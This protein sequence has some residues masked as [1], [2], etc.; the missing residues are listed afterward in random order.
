M[1]SHEIGDSIG[2]KGT[3][4]NGQP[5]TSTSLHVEPLSPP[6][7]V[8]KQPPGPR[9]EEQHLGMFRLSIMSRYFPLGLNSTAFVW[10]GASSQ[11]M[12]HQA[13]ASTAAGRWQLLINKLPNQLATL[14]LFHGP[15]IFHLF[16]GRRPLVGGALNCSKHP[17]VLL[18]F[19][20]FQKELTR[21]QSRSLVAIPTFDSIIRPTQTDWSDPCP[22]AIGSVIFFSFFFLNNKK[23][24]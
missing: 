15:G 8:L 3:G 12:T 1:A 24:E 21:V 20:L 5:V 6:P 22:W 23:I 14:A 2:P 19:C 10:R 7:N 9:E 11:K 16:P 18:S 13:V 17:I 4:E